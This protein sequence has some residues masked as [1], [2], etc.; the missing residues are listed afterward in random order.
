MTWV[1]VSDDFMDHPKVI[2]LGADAP[3]AVTLWLAGLGYCNRYLTDGHL[4]AGIVPRLTALP[5]GDLKRAAD[6]LVS[7]NLW[8]LR[9][10]GYQVHEYA[11]YQ[12]SRERVLAERTANRERQARWRDEHGNG[13]TN[14]VSNGERNGR[15]IPIPTPS[16]I[17]PTTPP[18]PPEVVE[19]YER[20]FGHVSEKKA[21]Y[22]SSIS[23]RWP[24]ERVI[25]GIK[26]EHQ[27][28]ATSKNIGGRLEA[29]L[30]AG[31]KREAAETLAAIEERIA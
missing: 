23:S 5:P 4:P 15:P 24:V 7:V 11:E 30:K 31:D 3:V 10:G 2:E 20:L 9:E 13:V 8:E 18:P 16:P 21:D 14:G 1:R 19:V 29:G 6:A 26:R 12:W 27:L 28:G 17:P 25:E 22:L